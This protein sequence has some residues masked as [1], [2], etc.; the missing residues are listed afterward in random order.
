[1]SC[2]DMLEDDHRR[3]LYSAIPWRVADPAHLVQPAFWNLGQKA[4]NVKLSLAML[5]R[6]NFEEIE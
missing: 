2:E 3:G 1:V 6:A 4:P 5:Y